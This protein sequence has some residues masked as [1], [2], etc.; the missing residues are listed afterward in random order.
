MN[1]YKICWSVVAALLFVGC[2][3]D[4]YEQPNASL[5]GVLR[6]AN[7]QEPVPGVVGNGNFGDLQF[8]QLDYGVDNPAGFTSAGFKADGS[9]ANTTLFDGQ[10]KLVPRGPYFYTDT[11]VLDLR[12]N[13]QQ[14]LAVL[15]FVDVD[16]RVGEVTSNSIAVYVKAQRNAGADAVASQ[17]ISQVVALLGST[18]GVNFNNYYVVNN[19]TADYRYVANTSSTPNAQIGETEYTYTF[20]NLKP[21]TTYYLRGASRVAERNPSSYYNYSE[22]VEV[23]T[24]D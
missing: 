16:L 1:I 4:N 3:K 11:V 5:Q 9:Y 19:N 14:D 21:G 6:D 10:Y 2:A 7:T 23:T 15:P 8:F 22:L 20:A 12:G 24:K 18:A 13:M 17:Q